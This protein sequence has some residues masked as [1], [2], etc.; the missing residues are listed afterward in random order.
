ML[1]GVSPDETYANGLLAGK[2]PREVLKGM[3][4]FE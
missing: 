4:V 3:N 2:N 1:A